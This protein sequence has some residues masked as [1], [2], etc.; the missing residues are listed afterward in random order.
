MRLVPFTSRIRRSD[1]P[2]ATGGILPRTRAQPDEGVGL[3]RDPIPSGSVLVDGGGRLRRIRRW[4][5]AGGSLARSR[6]L[7]VG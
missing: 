2:L 1:D 4:L 6:G 3:M 5:A 7:R